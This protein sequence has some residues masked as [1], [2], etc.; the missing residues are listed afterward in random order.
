M[1]SSKSSS[2]K[3]R[4]PRPTTNSVSSGYSKR[5][6]DMSSKREQLIP[7]PV[8][9]M[10]KTVKNT[11]T[12]LYAKSKKHK[13][14]SVS[15]PNLNQS[16]HALFKNMNTVRK[17]NPNT[18]NIKLNSQWFSSFTKSSSNQAGDSIK[19]ASVKSSSKPLLLDGKVPTVRGIRMNKSAQLRAEVNY[20]KLNGLANL[21][22]NLAWSCVTVNKLWISFVM[23]LCIIYWC[24]VYFKLLF[25]NLLATFVF[26]EYVLIVENSVFYFNSLLK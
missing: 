22:R 1:A 13:S 18:N 17:L 16:N 12:V 15:T 9:L 8:D 20:L 26:T 6:R 25:Y 21:N 10:V 5:R 3:T 7:K 19:F 24:S 14:S 2:R 4:I 11:K 23:L